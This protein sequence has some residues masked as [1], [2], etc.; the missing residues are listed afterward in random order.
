MLKIPLMITTS[1]GY[2][3]LYETR[4]HQ[5]LVLHGGQ[6]KN[7]SF[8]PFTFDAK[9]LSFYKSSHQYTVR[10]HI[11]SRIYTIIADIDTK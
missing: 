10:G 1:I 11:K 6:N 4:R 5:N 8:D 2:T 7:E 9:V 3:L